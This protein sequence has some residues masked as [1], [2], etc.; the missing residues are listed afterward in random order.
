ME[1]HTDFSQRVILHTEKMPWSPSP[2]A[3]VERRQLDRQGKEVARA[4]SIVR[5]ASGSYFAVHTHGG[6]E[7]I[8]VLEGVFSDEHGHYPSGSYLRNPP[9][10]THTLL[11]PNQAALSS[12]SSGSSIPVTHKPSV[13]KLNRV[14]GNSDVR[15]ASK[16][17]LLHEFQGVRTVLMRLEPDLQAQFHFHAGGEE[18]LVLEGDFADEHGEYSKGSWLRSPPG[19]SHSPKI[20]PNGA[21]LYLKSGQLVAPVLPLPN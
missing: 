15:K 3:G 4:T 17:Q 8:F 20:G 6:G 7:E 5:Y 19:S 11:F 1:L 12:S 18:I 14:A 16:V 13:N 21:L 2:A 10:I 9:G